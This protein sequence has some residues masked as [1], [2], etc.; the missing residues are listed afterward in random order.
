MCFLVWIVF[1]YIR[2]GLGLSV[3]FLDMIVMLII[4]HTSK[5][6]GAIKLQHKPRH[7]VL[8]FLFGE[9]RQRH[10]IQ[11]WVK[12]HLEAAVSIQQQQVAETVDVQFF[13]YLLKRCFAQLI[14]IQV[15]QTQRG[16]VTA[17]FQHEN[18]VPRKSDV[19][20][21]SVA[22]CFVKTLCMKVSEQT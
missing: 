11:L 10:G 22:V 19:G 7:L 1:Q 3:E 9:R 5:H 21:V 4:N 12:R 18:L 8:K 13:K 15:E 17:V 2:V 20:D 6:I 14:T 16:G